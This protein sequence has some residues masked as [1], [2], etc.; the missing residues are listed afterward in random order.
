MQAR[1]KEQSSKAALR[2]P[3]DRGLGDDRLGHIEQAS[4]RWGVEDDRL[5][6]SR[7][8]GVGLRLRA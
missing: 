2:P 8:R 5:G 3:S 6:Y 4:G 1:S 7:F